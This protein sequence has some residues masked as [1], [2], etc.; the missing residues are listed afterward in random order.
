MD[1]RTSSKVF[2][3]VNQLGGVYSKYFYDIN[4]LT[5]RSFVPSSR[6]PREKSTLSIGIENKQE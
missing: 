4:G 2:E 6:F 3:A 1:S 5:Y